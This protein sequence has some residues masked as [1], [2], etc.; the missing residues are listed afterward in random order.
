MFIICL[1]IIL[2]RE[3]KGNYTLRPRL[4]INLTFVH[5]MQLGNLSPC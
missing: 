3:N 1:K 2:Q 5:N 4:V